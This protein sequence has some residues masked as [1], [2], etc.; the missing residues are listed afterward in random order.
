MEPN[1]QKCAVHLFAWR[2]GRLKERTLERPKEEGKTYSSC[3]QLTW[4][5]RR[6]SVVAGRSRSPGGAPWVGDG[7]DLLLSWSKDKGS[8]GKILGDFQTKSCSPF[9]IS[10]VPSIKEECKQKSVAINI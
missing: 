3:D 6:S 5:K 9:F 7:G 1:K 8:R 4:R 10:L 2:L